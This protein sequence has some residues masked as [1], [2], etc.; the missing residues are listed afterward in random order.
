MRMMNISQTF[1]R[2]AAIPE[3]NIGLIQLDT[4]AGRSFLIC[5]ST[6]C[7]QFYKA[8]VKENLSTK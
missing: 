5:S 3:S 2:L 1:G 6:L 8:S 7:K 4:V